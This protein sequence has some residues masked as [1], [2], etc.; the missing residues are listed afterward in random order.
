MSRQ[1]TLTLLIALLP[2]ASFLEDCPLEGTINGIN[3]MDVII[4]FAT[5]KSLKCGLIPSELESQ[6][7]G[8]WKAKIL[9]KNTQLVSLS[10]K[11]NQVYIQPPS[12]SKT[13]NRSGQIQVECLLVNRGT[14]EIIYKFIRK[15]DI[16]PCNLDGTLNGVD[17]SDI[18]ISK[19]SSNRFSCG[20]LPRDIEDNLNAYWIGKILSKSV[21][22]S[23]NSNN[24]LILMVTHNRKVIIQPPKGKLIYDLTGYVQINCQLKSVHGNKIIF[25]F[26][27][28][29]TIH[30]EAIQLLYEHENRLTL[31]TNMRMKC[32]HEIHEKNNSINQY[33]NGYWLIHII[34]GH[35]DIISLKIIN[36]TSVIQPPYNQIVYTKPGKVE[37]V[38]SFIDH[39]TKKEIYSKVKIIKIV[40]TYRKGTLNGINN[41]DILLVLVQEMTCKNSCILKYD[42]YEIGFAFNKSIEIID[43]VKTGTIN[44]YD[45]LDGIVNIGTNHT[46]K[47]GLL[48]EWS[49]SLYHGYWEARLLSSANYPLISVTSCYNKA[50]IGPP[51]NSS[52]YYLTGSVT[53]ECIFKN[54]ENKQTIYVFNKN[55]IIKD[56]NL[57]GSLDGIDQFNKIVSLGSNKTFECSLLPKSYLSVFNGYWEAQII[58][59]LPNA[60]SIVKNNNTILIQPPIGNTVYNITDRLQI[61]CELKADENRII[62]KFNKFIDITKCNLHGT[63]NAIDNSNIDIARDSKDTIKCGLLPSSVEDQLNAT[64]YG[65]IISTEPQKASIIHESSQAIIKPPNSYSIYK[66]RG[67]CI[68]ECI[69]ANRYDNTTIF[70]FKKTIRIQEESHLRSIVNVLDHRETILTVG[71]SN[72]I[73]IYSIPAAYLN[74]F[75]PKYDLTIVSGPKDILEKYG[76]NEYM[77]ARPNSVYAKS[78][79]VKIRSV[80]KSDSV[81]IINTTKIVRIIDLERKGTLNGIDSSDIIAPIGSNKV[82]KCG[83]LQG[84]TAQYQSEDLSNNE[85]VIRPPYCELYYKIKGNVTIECTYRYV[86]YQIEFTFN[87]TISIIDE[88]MEGSLNGIDNSGI[89][90]LNGTYR[91]MKCHLLPK[92]LEDGVYSGYWNIEIIKG[93]S[94]EILTVE[95]CRGKGI[96]HPPKGSQKFTTVGEATVQCTFKEY[97]SDRVIYSFNKSILVEDIRVLFIP[98]S[99]EL[100]VMNQSRLFVYSPGD[101]VLRLIQK[102]Y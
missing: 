86:R 90:I 23:S 69:F 39:Q 58:S 73:M 7:N 100:L 43:G 88:S 2:L 18:H 72:R 24:D 94:N 87:K 28:T 77:P 45:E 52:V 66:W 34:G 54:H 31:G 35:I 25:D 48:P 102:V 60:I 57:Q 63:L 44:G 11:D 85:V 16:L 5:N 99:G 46:F 27:K 40:N 49:E 19:G 61:Q 38:C 32:D 81:T 37:I 13:Y 9:T 83:I 64:W 12:E 47:C 79:L 4:P 15:I 3:T 82:Y 1:C 78:G 101:K 67:H 20:L 96:I 10:Y 33:N 84:K 59:G 93:Q 74:L 80:I 91:P 17:N 98:S 8:S 14:N 70:T 89:I 51:F 30:D 26:N 6:L 76:R 75:K 41:R 56:C 21:V 50:V 42:A 92:S 97:T 22:S 62:Y 53:V 55:I 29:I 71:S 36:R 95:M 65:H 68:V